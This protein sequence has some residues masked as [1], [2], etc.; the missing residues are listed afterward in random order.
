MPSAAGQSSDD[1]GVPPKLPT[2]P[3]IR[4]QAE[5]GAGPVAGP[6][7]DKTQQRLQKVVS[8]QLS[9]F[10]HNDFVSALGCSVPEFRQS[11][12]PDAFRQLIRSGY[13]PMMDYRK[14]TFGP[15]RR[16]ADSAFMPVEIVTAQG[17]TVAYMYILRHL[18]HSAIGQTTLKKAPGPH[19]APA[20]D[21]W[22]VDTVSPLSLDQDLRMPYPGSGEPDHDIKIREA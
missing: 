4:P 10:A 2:P 14:A 9:A 6:V 19:S 7:D 18:G 20:V 3:H 8:K 13:A 21:A 22:L 5:P 11:W 1:N 15:A 16:A 17:N 12:T